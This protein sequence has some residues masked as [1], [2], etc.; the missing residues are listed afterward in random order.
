MK[1]WNIF[2]HTFVSLIIAIVVNYLWGF[3][4]VHEAASIGIIGAVDGPTSIF[5]S[6]KNLIAVNYLIIKILFLA[7]YPGII[8]FTIMMLFF[9]PIKKLLMSK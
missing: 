4:T 1:E 9:K 5:V 7:A 6:S 2:R 8:A 3:V